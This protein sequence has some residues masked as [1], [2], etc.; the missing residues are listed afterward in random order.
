MVI[1]KKSLAA[2]TLS[3]SLVSVFSAVPAQARPAE[4]CIVS[5]SFDGSCLLQPGMT[6][7]GV[8]KAGN[9]GPGGFGGNGGNAF[10]GGFLGGL[11]GVGGVGG[12]GAKI[13]YTYTNTSGSTMT[14]T[15]AIGVNGAPGV[16]GVDGANGVS[17]IVSYGLDGIAGSAGGSGVS[18]FVESNS[19][20]LFLANQGTGGEGGTG[21]TGGTDTNGVNGISGAVGTAGADS[22]LDTTWLEDPFAS[23]VFVGVPSV[24]PVPD[25]APTLAVTGQ[26]PQ[27][28][29]GTGILA[30]LLLA[31]GASGLVLR[32]RMGAKN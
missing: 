1:S 30:G 13:P 7:T 16:V 19:V 15:F 28:D 32:R 27:Q 21:G 26:N 6:I 9:G 20:A 17:E 23:I 10:T 31:L 25:P 14:L 12:A 8:L 22:S 18:T 5:L 11:G 4:D 3:V 29:L 2:V 24:D